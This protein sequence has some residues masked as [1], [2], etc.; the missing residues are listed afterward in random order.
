LGL[1]YTDTWGEKVEINASYLFD[2]RKNLGE[3]SL[4]R[5]FVLPDD[6]GQQ[7]TESSTNTRRN[8]GHRFDMRLE[9]QIDSNNHILFRPNFSAVSDKESSFFT[10]RTINNAGPLNE[11]E[12]HRR[13]NNSDIDFNSRLFYSHR[14]AKKGRSLRLGLQTGDHRNE[15][16][17]DR[18]AENAY[19]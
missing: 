13:A 12:N 15:D 14:F 16:D 17:A 2:Q 4:F 9:Y 11:T 19:F 3:A 5:E 18:M 6:D 10:G 1:N 7:Y 8:L